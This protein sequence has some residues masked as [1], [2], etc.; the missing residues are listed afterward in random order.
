MQRHD[1]M[2]RSHHVGVCEGAVEVEEVEAL[3]VELLAHSCNGGSVEPS[4]A[5]V[6]H[7]QAVR[8]RAGSDT[9]QEHCRAWHV[10]GVE[11]CDAEREAIVLHLR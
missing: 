2:I 6:Q 10:V 5:G 8:T 3:I 7:R 11:R 9:E 1:K 4:V